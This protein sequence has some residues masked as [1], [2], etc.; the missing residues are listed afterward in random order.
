[1]E[2][3]FPSSQDL[4][5]RVTPHGFFG[6]RKVFS[7]GHAVQRVGFLGMWRWLGVLPVQKHRNQRA[8][9]KNHGLSH[10]FLAL[11]EN[12]TNDPLALILL[13]I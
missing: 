2:V 6:E 11:F 9:H 4:N 13:I 8:T 12:W 3:E 5:S 7:A 10:F 1:M